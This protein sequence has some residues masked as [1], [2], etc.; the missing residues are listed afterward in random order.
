M[1]GIEWWLGK[2][3]C[4]FCCV[5]GLQLLLAT[6]GSLTGFFSVESFKS[7]FQEY[8][9]YLEGVP[10]RYKE[11]VFDVPCYT[12]RNMAELEVVDLSKSEGVEYSYEIF[13]FGFATFTSGEISVQ[14]VRCFGKRVLMLRVVVMRIAKSQLQGNRSGLREFGIGYFPR[15][16]FHKMR[17]GQVR[18]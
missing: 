9:R 3:R 18:L 7:F 5:R 14:G 17:N 6:C 1:F 16:G 4:H 2:I 12:A 8:P 15:I 10:L 11:F 13:L